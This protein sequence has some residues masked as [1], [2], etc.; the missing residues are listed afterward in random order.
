MPGA[1][2][3]GSKQPRGHLRL[4]PQ[5]NR[6]YLEFSPFYVYYQCIVIFRA[7]RYD[8]P[9]Q[10]VCPRKKSFAEWADRIRV[11]LVDPLFFW[12]TEL[13]CTDTVHPFN[14]SF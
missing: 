10:A 13:F 7:H 8:T 4:S 12:Y 3:H 2:V 1:T 11:A 5:Q 6:A 14:S 9:G